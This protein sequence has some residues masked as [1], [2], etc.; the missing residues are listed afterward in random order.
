VRILLPAAFFF[1]FC[2]AFAEEPQ[3]HW[4]AVNHA[5][6]LA[7]QAKDYAKLRTTLDE[8]QPLMPG[9]PRVLYNMAASDAVLGNKPKALEELQNLAAAGLIYDLAADADFEGLRNLPEYAA[10]VKHMDRNRGSIAGATEVQLFKERDLLPEDIAYDARKRGFL[11][12]SVSGSKIIHADSGDVLA[13]TDW[14]V[15]A[16]RIDTSRR[17]LWAAIAWLPHCQACKPEDKDKTAL[18]SYQLDSGVLLKRYDSPV[19][20]MFGDMTISRKGDIYVSEGIHGAVFKLADGKFERLDTPGEFPSPQ[21]PALSKD[22]RTLYVSDYVRGIAALD[23]KTHQ[24]KWLNPASDVILSG[25]DGLYVYRNSFLA[26][27]NGTN[28]ARIVRWSLDLKRQQILET[29]TPGLGEPTHGTL[30]GDQ[31]YFLANTGWSEYD[32]NGKKKSGSAPVVSSIRK[33]DLRHRDL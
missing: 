8:L 9:N 24:V 10:V 21:T 17:I 20:G 25:I 30:V 13:K 1:S 26:V 11:V 16:L 14:S 5:A 31:F 23:L 29:N 3:P 4:M 12:S 15:L 19:P 22:E 32:E 27:Q 2:W 33:I 28:P 18:V 6:G 7:I